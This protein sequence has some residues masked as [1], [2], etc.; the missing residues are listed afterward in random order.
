M[1][2]RVFNRSSAVRRPAENRIYGI[3]KRAVSESLRPFLIIRK[4]EV[5]VRFTLDLSGSMSRKRSCV[6]LTKYLVENS[7]ACSKPCT[8]I[9]CTFSMA[10]RPC[11]VL[12]QSVYPLTLG[13]YF[14]SAE[15]NFAIN[16][17]ILFLS[18]CMRT[19]L[20]LFAARTALART[21]QLSS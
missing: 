6:S 21:F 17:T 8:R 1:F 11:I 4:A 15:I 7:I 20:P 13:S 3:N 12:E 9:F 16:L 10:K 18:L 19:A 14:L 2:T 5:N